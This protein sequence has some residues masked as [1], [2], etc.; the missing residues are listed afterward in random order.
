MQ[1]VVCR[2][3][4]HVSAQCR[5]Y[6]CVAEIMIMSDDDDDDDDDDDSMAL[7]Y[8]LPAAH[9]PFFFFYVYLDSVFTVWL[10]CWCRRRYR[11]GVIYRFLPHH[12]ILLRDSRFT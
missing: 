4:A 12:L 10:G 2:L 8:S 11:V 3:C 7:C 9:M 6:M 5:Q 1:C